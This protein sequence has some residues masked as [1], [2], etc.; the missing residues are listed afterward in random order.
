MSRLRDD[1]DPRAPRGTGGIM[2]PRAPL[3]TVEAIVAD[4]RVLRRILTAANVPMVP[5]V[6]T[7]SDFHELGDLPFRLAERATFVVRSARGGDRGTLPVARVERGFIGP[8]GR[9]MSPAALNRYVAHILEGA[10]VDGQ[11]DGAVIEEP[12]RAASLFQHIGAAGALRIRV[13]TRHGQAVAAELHPLDTVTAPD[14]A[15]APGVVVLGLE[16]EHGVVE[17]F[18]HRAAIGAA[19]P[20]IVSALLGN[21]VRGWSVICAAAARAAKAIGLPELAIDLV[22]DPSRGPLVVAVAAVPEM[23]LPAVAP[24]ASV[25]PHSMSTRLA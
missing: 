7:I 3:A 18:W 12:I 11:S 4:L 15:P 23:T 14:S 16:P 9:H 19:H 1:Y 20:P 22:V 21:S 8:N 13:G 24:R 17:R 5:L 6:T 25:H 10:F 2:R